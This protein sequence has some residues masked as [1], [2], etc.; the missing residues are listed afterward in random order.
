MQEPAPSVR[1]VSRRPRDEIVTIGDLE[2]AVDIDQL[3]DL[4]GRGSRSGERVS[5]EY[6]SRIANAKGFPDPIL[7][8]PRLRLWHRADVE[9]WLDRNRPGWRGEK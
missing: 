8:H 2:D 6:A 1:G 9:A 4:L 5:R 3:R 7:D